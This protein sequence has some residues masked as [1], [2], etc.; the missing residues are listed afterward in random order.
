MSRILASVRLG[1]ARTA[2]ARTA[3]L[4][5]VLLLMIAALRSPSLFTTSGLG[6]ALA[7]AAPL[8]LAGMALTPIA[9]VGRGDVNLAIGPLMGF[10]NVVLVQFFINRGLNAPIKLIGVALAVGVL[11]QALLGLTSALLRIEPI[12]VALG[13]YL[14]LAGLNLVILP[15]PGGVAPPWLVAWGSGRSVFSPLL[16]LLVVGGLLWWA[17]TKTPLFANLRLTGA[18]E[19][20]AYVSGVPT[21]AMRVVAHAVGGF[22]AGLA[23][24]CFTALIGS[25]D[26]NQGT[27]YTLLA[28]TA[29][30][31]GGTSLAG[32][33][34][35]MTGSV[36]AAL[37]IFLISYVLATFRLGS[38]AAYV[39][40]FV[41]GLVLILAMLTALL[42]HRRRSAAPAAARWTSSEPASPVA[43]AAAAQPVVKE[44]L[45]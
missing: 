29:L 3:T 26:P 1:L 18:D 38:L 37:D 30:V 5:L 23:G 15:R 33:S 41:Y 19:R 9:M 24:L 20:A 13:G 21:S 44:P 31:L 8:I 45:P 43:P 2:Y 36:I 32:G 11:V 28:V 14:T 22:Y 25:G 4:L 17:F 12:I 39:N 7:G 42:A 10:V 6:G 34:G 35:G 40:Q 16:V 27:T